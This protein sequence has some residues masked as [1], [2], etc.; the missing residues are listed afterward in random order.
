LKTSYRVAFISVLILLI[1]S[2]DIIYAC[3]TCYGDPDSPASEGINYAI[4]T[5]LGVTGGVLGMIVRAIYSIG[6]KSRNYNINFKS[7]D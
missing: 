5:L 2:Y 1:M 7:E 6:S 4:I 3:S